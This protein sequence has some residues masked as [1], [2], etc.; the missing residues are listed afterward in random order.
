[1][2]RRFAELVGADYHSY[3]TKGM[4]GKMHLHS[5]PD[6]AADPRLV[7]REMMKREDWP[8]FFHFLIE[9]GLAVYSRPIFGAERR[10]YYLSDTLFTD[11]TGLL[12]DRA[13]EWMERR[14]DAK[15]L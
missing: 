11:T 15:S 1:M 12:R 2:N 13:V 7:L 8:E 5:N 6:F 10:P 3:E 14:K 9:K 4:D